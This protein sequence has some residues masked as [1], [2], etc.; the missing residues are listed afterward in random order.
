MYPLMAERIADYIDDYR[1]WPS[2]AEVYLP[3]GSAPP[4]GE[5]F[6]QTD[7]GRSLQY[8]ADQEAAASGRGRAAGLQAA[9]DAFYRGDLARTIVDY[10]RDHGGLLAME[11]MAAFR[12]GIEPP[13]RTRFAGVDVYACAPGARGRPSC[14]RSTSSTGSTWPGWGTTRPAICTR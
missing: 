8:M 10:H 3:G 12:V 6:E 14:R 7:L 13:V 11:D 5:V 1:R 4:V 2:N 9:R